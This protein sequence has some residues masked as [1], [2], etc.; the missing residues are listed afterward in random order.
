M[1]S[2]YKNGKTKSDQ[3]VNAENAMRS[4]RGSVNY[5]EALHELLRAYV[6]DCDD[7]TQAVIEWSN[8]PEA[9]VNE[10]GEVWFNRHWASDDEISSFVDWLHA[11]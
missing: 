11:N 7:P 9:E 4:A 6:L 3:V 2:T 5:R 10:D 8:D 1:R